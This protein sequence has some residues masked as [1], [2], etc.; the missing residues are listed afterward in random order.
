MGIFILAAF[1]AVP[2][3]EIALFIEVGGLIGLGWTLAVIVATA[4]AGTILLRVQG[5]ATLERARRAFDQGQLPAHAL[6]DGLCL[7]FAGALL[8]T[9]GFATDMVGFLLFVPAVRA[10]LR[11]FAA[12][13]ITFF[14][15]TRGF[16]GEGRPPGDSRGPI[17]DGDYEDLTPEDQERTRSE[18]ERF[19]R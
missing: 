15:T 8:L 5:L 16:H 7:L 6:F 14:A 2:L 4:V 12:R 1:I 10:A 3:N 9:P 17:I 13:H 11:R 19:I 18:P